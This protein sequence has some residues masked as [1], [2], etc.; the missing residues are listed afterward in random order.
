MSHLNALRF[1]L[2]IVVISSDS[3]VF[4]QS[5]MVIPTQV[6]NSTDN[7][8]VLVKQPDPTIRQPTDIDV[9]R[10]T[11]PTTNNTPVA[12]PASTVAPTSA[13]SNVNVNSTTPPAAGNAAPA[14][15]NAPDLSGLLSKSDAATGVEVQQRNAIVSD[16]RVRGLRTGQY[17]STG[18]GAPFSPAR[19]DLDTPISKISPSIVQNVNVVRGPY[20]TLVGPGFAFLN[21]TTLDSPRSQGNCGGYEWHGTS[22]FGY[23]TNG[24]RVNGLQ[25]ATMAGTDWGLLA[26]YNVLQGNDYRAGDG[27]RIPSSYLSHNYNIAMGYDLSDKTSIEFK[28]MGNFQSNLEFPGLFFDITRSDTQAYSFRIQTRDFGAIDLATATVWYNQT[29][30]EGNTQSGAKQM[31]VRSLL[32]SAFEEPFTKNGL[33]PQGYNFTDNS[34]TTFSERSVGYRLSAQVGNNKDQFTFTTGHDLNSFRQSLDE[35]INFTQTGGPSLSRIILGSNPNAYPTLTQFQSIPTST[36]VDPGLFVESM[37]PLGD[38]LKVRSGGR[39]D[40]FST[41]SNPRLISGNVDLFGAPQGPFPG[42]IDRFNLNP[43][44]YSTNPD[45]NQS[46][47]RNYLLLAG[48]A[49]AEYQVAEY[50]KLFANYGYAERAPTLTELYASG[51]FIGVLQQ[52]TSRLIGDPNLSKEKINQVD[53]GIRYDA[54]YLKAG[55]SGYY[56]W[57]HDYITYDANRLSNVGLSQLVFSNTDLATLA[58]TEMYLQVRA[59]EWLTP[60]ATL[61][62]VQGIDQTHVDNRRP[63][64]LASSRRNDPATRQFTTS[65]EPLPQIPPLESRLGFRLHS[66]EETPRWQVEFSARIV[67]GQNDV[68]T[69]LGELPSSGFTTFDI[70]GFWQMTKYCQLT[71]GVENIGDKLYRE[72]LDPISANLAQQRGMPVAPLYRQGT[73]F[74]FNTQLSY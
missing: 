55:I 32:S 38:K 27:T 30:G 7:D 14:S 51:P 62:Y 35:N 57:I 56:S 70:R 20:T 6:P 39:I 25:T 26:S 10:Q 47:N 68:A 9:T 74:F 16:P 21:V 13:S 17:L 37:A 5:A 12:P 60:F 59:T 31:F 11:P 48:F 63:G 46:L 18:D 58:G 1:A 53:I 22:A 69:S 8:I 24:S 28:A 41:N 67:N 29:T 36:S 71:A 34:F 50:T 54:E 15:L 33:G 73:N 23:Q 45:L 49:S 52:G 72:H 43:N 2:L 19:L 44:I 3:A 65:T 61:S 42:N 4:G 40:F 66:R 64:N